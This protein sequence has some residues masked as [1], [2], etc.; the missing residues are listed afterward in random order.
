MTIPVT[1]PLTDAPATPGER[2]YVA[3]QRELIWRKFRRHRLAM[4]SLGVLAFL[5]VLA[6]VSDFVAPYNVNTKFTGFL[7]TPPQVVRLFGD[8]GVRPYVQGFTRTNDPVTLAFVFKPD[9]QKKVPLHFF[10]RGEP[11]KLLGLFPTNL[12]LF[13]AGEE[14]VFLFGTD[15]LGRDVFSRTVSALK[16]SLFVGLVG[17]ALSFILGVVLG[18]VSG[19]FGGVTDLIVQRLIEFL[20]SIPTI[21]LWLALSAALP[22]GWSSVAVFF[23]ITIILSLIGWSG[24]A[25]VVRGKFLELREENY[26]TASL[27]AGATPWWIITRHLI[28]AFSSYLIVQVTLLIPSFILG[29]TALSFLGLGIQPPAVSLGTLLQDAQ[30]IR[31]VSLYPWLFIPAAFVVAVVLAF[32]FVGDGLRDAADP[33]KQ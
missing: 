12:H 13:G 14:Q 18:G 7:N 24:I 33:Y 30:N 22:P 16:I 26:V 8:G 19:Y 29:E 25:R 21:P 27:L 4:V 28:P 9:P 10:V 23:G 15:S 6:L 20:L 32:N 11:Y 3:S 31:A 1:P 5:Y 2:Y 17:V